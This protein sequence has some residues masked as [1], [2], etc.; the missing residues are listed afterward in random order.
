MASDQNRKVEEFYRAFQQERYLPAPGSKPSLKA[1]GDSRVD[2]RMSLIV[3]E[4]CELIAAVYNEE[5]AQEMEN[6]W[7][8]LFD[9]HVITEENR[10]YDV[11]ATADATGDLRYVIEGLDL[12]ANIPSEAIFNEIHVSNMSKLDDEGNPVISDGT[13]K[14]KGKILKGDNYFAPD[15][16]SIIEGRTPDRTPVKSKKENA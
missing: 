1:M 8:N 14:P 13:S 12:E 15:L 10:N 16:E 7:L 5:A 6:T 11:V 3:E 4:F 2:L 9:D